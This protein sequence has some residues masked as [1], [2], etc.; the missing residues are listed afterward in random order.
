MQRTLKRKNLMLSCERLPFQL[1]CIFF[2][3]LH[4]LSRAGQVVF[5]QIYSICVCLPVLASAMS[6]VLLVDRLIRFCGQKLFQPVNGESL[7]VFRI[8]FGTLMIIDLQVERAFSKV[9]LRWNDP[10]ECRFPLFEW[11]KPLPG[12][13]MCLLYLVLF[14]GAIGVTLG[15]KFKI[16][17]SL[18]SL[19][20]WYIFLL[21]KSYWNNHSYLF[22]L[23]SVM[24]TLSNANSCWSMDHGQR[25]SDGK[26]PSWQ[27]FIIRFQISLVYFLAGVKKCNDE[28]IGG[29]SM[30]YLSSHWVFT[31]FRLFLPSYFV[32]LV[33][34]HWGGFIIDSSV[35]ILFW[36]DATRPIGYFFC[37]LF[38]LMNSQMFAIGMFPFVMLIVLPIYSSPDWPKSLLGWFASVRLPFLNETISDDHCS[39]VIQKSEI[40]S[41]L[42]KKQIK[43]DTT[44][45]NSINKQEKMSFEGT[46]K[47]GNEGKS[48]LSTSEDSSCQ[49][50]DIHNIVGKNLQE[51]SIKSPEFSWKQRM[52][53]IALIIYI[54]FQIALPFSHNITKGY[55]TW[56]EGVYGYSWDM[57][58][59]NWK[60]LDKK[61]TVTVHP[62]EYDLYLNPEKW[63]PNNRWTHHADMAKKLATCIAD[64][65][66]LRYNLTSIS[67]HLDVWISLNGRFTQRIYDPRVD[68]LTAEW[69]PFQRPSWVMPL[70]TE[71]NDWR[72][73][74]RQREDEMIKQT[75][76]S[77]IVFMADFPGLTLINYVDPA[78]EKITL[79]VIQGW[80][81]VEVEGGLVR[82]MQKD[83]HCQLPADHFVQITVIKSEPALYSFTYHNLK[84][85]MEKVADNEV[86]SASEK[87][88]LLQK[89][90]KSFQIIFDSLIEIGSQIY[91]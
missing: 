10:E 18:Y 61:M 15:Y 42:T 60:V 51:I 87:R 56:T 89:W 30:R 77:G 7:A 6:Q 75:D 43:N 25:L 64:K 16:S 54:T 82:I 76:D 86:Q 35:G 34:I 33:I 28:W 48:S 67:V 20:Y 8:L 19:V 55:N 73:W 81:K 12:P 69:S 1:S 40:D 27:Y 26:V 50:K 79:R 47:S 22:G 90:C 41:V 72:S 31:P 32:D 44:E 29:H 68:I 2:S 66:G 63:S 84:N 78:L 85:V 52:I 45:G 46:Q 53:M 59:H 11:I 58:V 57:M 62:E 21:D 37:A 88:N 9:D 4:L 38:N 3:D 14:F 65:I 71:Y 17:S 36:F 70:L 13:Y 39:K 80:L 5:T 91:Q 74:L 83:D 49:A 23:I 24:L